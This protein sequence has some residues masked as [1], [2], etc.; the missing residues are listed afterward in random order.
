VL[1]A[2]IEPLRPPFSWIIFLTMLAILGASALMYLMLV[3]RWTSRRQWVSLARWTRESGFR[4]RPATRDVLPGPLAELVQSDLDVLFHLCD[5]RNTIVQFRTLPAAPGAAPPRWNV[6]LRRRS[7][8]TIA[9]LR[10]A[11]QP[12]NLIDLLPLSKFATLT[13]GERFVAY[14]VQAHAARALA[15]SRV[16]ALLPQD[17]GL[18][19]LEQHL[20]MDFSSRPFD[21]IEFGR[22]MV[23]ADQAGQVVG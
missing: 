7:G 17:V 11:A 1:L 2:T 22:M 10:P 20:I 5:S 19:L 21:P 3:R 12:L 18:I 13:L 14:A 4:M 8:G 15:E 9:A 23:L 6:L 16:A